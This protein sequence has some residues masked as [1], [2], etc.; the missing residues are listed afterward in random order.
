MIKLKE[1]E[2]TM[3]TSPMVMGEYVCKTPSIMDTSG[4]EGFDYED[5]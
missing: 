2:R 1:K 4:H 5:L 3:Y